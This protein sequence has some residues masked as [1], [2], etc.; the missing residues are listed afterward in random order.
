M[1]SSQSYEYCIDQ[2]LILTLL[3]NNELNNIKHKISHLDNSDIISKNKLELLSTIKL[4]DKQKLKKCT[5]CNTDFSRI[6][7]LKEH[8]LVE[9]F[10]NKL[11]KDNIS[12]LEINNSIE[13]DHNN[14]NNTINNITNNN[15]NNTTNIYLGLKSPIPFDDIWDTT[16]I[17]KFIKENII[18]SKIMYTN[19]LSEILQNEKNLNVIIEGDDTSGIVYKNDIEKYTEM[20]SY[21]IFDKTMEKLKEHLLNI[22]LDCENDYIESCIQYSK[23]NINEKFNN[24]VQK[25][26][27]KECVNNMMKVIFNNNKDEALKIYKNVSKENNLDITG[28]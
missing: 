26:D 3:P 5:I 17:E 28:Y 21:D 4:I 24:Y 25:S 14:I 11:K 7:D 13:G 19:L 22:N 6:I 18:F 9:C 20:K 10:Y 27:T 16:K 23:K 15:N 8:F 2:L 1:R 12:K